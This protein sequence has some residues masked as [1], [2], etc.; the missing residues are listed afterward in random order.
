MGGQQNVDCDA[1]VFM[2]NSQGKLES[3]NDLIYFGNLKSASNAVVHTGDNITGDGDGD[4]EQV[5][6]NLDKVPAHVNKLLFVVNIYNCVARK[7]HFGMIQNAFI[8]VVD[9]STKKEIVRYN[10]SDDYSSKT[11]LIVGTIYRQG[12]TWQFS[13]VGEGTSDTCL[14]DVVANLAEIECA[15]G[16]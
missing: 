3:N 4:D 12:N 16:R 2:L 9:N 15:Y 14:K 10:L 13:A 5:L 11:A 8:R 6:V 7:Q 1:S